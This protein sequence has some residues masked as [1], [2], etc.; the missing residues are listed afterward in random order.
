MSTYFLDTSALAKR[1]MTEP[2]SLWIR[3]WILPRKGNT[4]VI[5]RLATIEIISMMI[6]KHRGSVVSYADFVRNRDNFFRHLRQQYIVVEF[7]PSVLSLARRLLTRHPLRTLDAIQLAAGLKA[8]QT[9]PGLTFMSA[10]TRLLTAAAAEGLAV[11]DPNLH[12]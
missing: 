8:A 2:G 10:D 4:V 9:F 5:S 7:E 11:D 6:R 12:P 1:Y 3:S